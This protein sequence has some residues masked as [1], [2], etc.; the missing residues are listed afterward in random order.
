MQIRCQPL[1]L[2]IQAICLRRKWTLSLAESCTGGYVASCLTSQPGASFY[3]LGSIVCYSNE[4]KKTILG[5]QEQ[6]LQTYGAVSAEVVKEMSEGVSH[7]IK[8][9][10]SLAVSGIAGPGGGTVTQPVGTIWAAI[11]Q[12]GKEAKVW[13]FYLQG[14]RQEI[15]EEAAEILLARLLELLKTRESVMQ[16]DRDSNEDEA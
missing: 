14:S 12:Q 4:V 13:T 16:N 10:Y 9:D 3:F 8:S 5:V 1:I 15:I 7:L 11:K 6:T 2:A